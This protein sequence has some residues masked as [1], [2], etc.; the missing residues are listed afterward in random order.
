[1]YGVKRINECEKKS[2]STPW[3]PVLLKGFCF[4]FDNSILI[5]VRKIIHKNIISFAKEKFPPI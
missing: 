4:D 3:K 5:Y 1:M 2:S